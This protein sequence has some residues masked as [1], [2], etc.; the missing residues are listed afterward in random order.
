[1]AKNG[2]DKSLCWECQLRR[3]DYMFSV[4]GVKLRHGLCRE[5]YERKACGSHG[6]TGLGS[7]DRRTEEMKENIRET[8]FGVER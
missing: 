2:K 7:R 4:T 1:M 3:V 8:K 6:N 5:C